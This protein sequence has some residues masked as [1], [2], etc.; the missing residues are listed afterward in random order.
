M[1]RVVI[2]K[3]M[4]RWNWLRGSF[5]PMGKVLTTAYPPNSKNPDGI[6]RIEMFEKVKKGEG[7]I[8]LN[9]RT[10]RKRGYLVTEFHL[11]PK[12]ASMLSISLSDTLNREGVIGVVEQ[13]DSPPA[14]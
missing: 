7:D 10:F 4:S 5:L 8:I 1:R 6:V 12:M 13:S 9:Q 11:S 3:F 2:K 14:T